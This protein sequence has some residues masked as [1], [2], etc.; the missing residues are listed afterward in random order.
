MSPALAY[1]TLPALP[2]TYDLHTLTDHEY[3]VAAATRAQLKASIKA[4]KLPCVPLPF[5]R[6]GTFCMPSKVAATELH[7]ISAQLASSWRAPRRPSLLHLG[8]RTTRAPN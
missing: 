3:D 2:P 1:D 8:E 4:A 6:L 7:M 5:D